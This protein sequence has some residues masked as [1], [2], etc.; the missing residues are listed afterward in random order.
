M[1]SGVIS[2][3]ESP[4]PFHRPIDFQ[5]S[6]ESNQPFAS[7]GAF[8]IQ[9][10][11]VKLFVHALVAHHNKTLQTSQIVLAICISDMCC[12]CS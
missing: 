3:T 5:L 4:K 8:S 1:N 7:H 11:S 2:L 9:I 12:L 6:D 10:M